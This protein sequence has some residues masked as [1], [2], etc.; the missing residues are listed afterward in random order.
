V[1]KFP[2]ERR[3]EGFSTLTEYTRVEPSSFAT[4]SDRDANSQ[5]AGP[6]PFTDL[7]LSTLSLAFAATLDPSDML[8]YRQQ[9]SQ[10]RPD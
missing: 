10:R 1:L 6:K 3:T 5:S 7:P 8:P 4:Q 2:D 9:W